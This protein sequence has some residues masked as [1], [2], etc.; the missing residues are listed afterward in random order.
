VISATQAVLQAAAPVSVDAVRQSPP[1][2]CFSATMRE[3]SQALKRFLLEKLYRHPQ[4]LDTTGQAQQVVR[5]L[6]ACYLTQ[7][8]RLPESHQ[9]RLATAM[10]REPV[11]ERALARTVADY[12]AGMTDRFALREHQRLTGQRLLFEPFCASS[13][14]G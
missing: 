14:F 1:L 6:F 5:D 7:P 13:P 8:D 11:P 12:I 2:I 4:V 9:R 10:T 3:Q